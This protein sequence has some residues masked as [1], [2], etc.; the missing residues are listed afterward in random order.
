MNRTLQR[1]PRNGFTLV[2]LL[3]VI[4]IVVLLTGILLVV[5]TKALRAADTSATKFLM[6]SMTSGLEQFKTDFGY[7]PPLIRDDFEDME[8]DRSVLEVQ[9]NA[10]EELRRYRYFSMSSLS[11]YMLGV[12]RLETSDLA[13]PNLDPDRHDG[14]GG[15]G[16]RDPGADK[17]WGGAR[18]RS[19]NNPTRTGRVYG[20]YVDI[21]DGDSTRAVT[22]L[23]LGSKVDENPRKPG[24]TI[25]LQ[26][27]LDQTLPLFV[28]AWGT[29]IR[30]YRPGWQT[31][32]PTTGEFTLDYAPIE[33]LSIETIRAE[34]APDS[35]PVISSAPFF[36]LSAGPNR[37]FAGE[38]PVPGGESS[39]I[40]F[41][42]LSVTESNTEILDRVDDRSGELKKMLNMIGDN[43]RTTP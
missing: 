6:S 25:S 28:D 24:E 8:P 11:V 30:Y 36:L 42:Q 35:D 7:Y 19:K 2:E 29:A 5:T 18:D 31:R 9:P 3:V 26:S 27:D 39:D 10:G 20:P 23:D 17:S 43:I 15:P 21:G 32:R 1:N 16:I 4:S 33:L 37:K 38:R 12:G 14:I 41:D 22:F 34:F 40:S 13:T